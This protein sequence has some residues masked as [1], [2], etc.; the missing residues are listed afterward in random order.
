[1]NF[2]AGGTVNVHNACWNWFVYNLLCW[3][4][5]AGNSQQ[6]PLPLAEAAAVCSYIA[7][8]RLADE[9]VPTCLFRT[10]SI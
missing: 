2:Q 7:A 1:M 6:L 10:A 9:A 5:L 4:G 8:R 3:L